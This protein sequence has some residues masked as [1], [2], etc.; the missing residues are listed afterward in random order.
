MGVFT[1]KTAVIL[2]VFMLLMVAITAS[3][4]PIR[5]SIT[6]ASP[7]KLG[8]AD[9]KPGDYTITADDTKVSLAYNGKVVAEAKVEWKDG[10]SK[11]SQTS[12]LI[13]GDEIKEIRFGGKTRYAVVQ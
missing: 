8:G 6:L 1:R 12:L 11:A 10:T 3:A 4:Q 5:S 7:A 13:A 2:G 9:L